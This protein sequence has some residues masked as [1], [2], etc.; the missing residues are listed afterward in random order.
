MLLPSIFISVVVCT[1]EICA[2]LSAFPLFIC[3]SRPWDNLS[4]VSRDTCD[5]CSH[6]EA[7]FFMPQTRGSC[8]HIKG[9]YDNHLSCI[10]CCGCCRFH[11]CSVCNALSDA[12]WD[13]VHSRRLYSDRAMG[14]KEAKRKKKP[15]KSVSR[16]S[17]SSRPGLERT[18]S[19]DQTGSAAEGP[20]DDFASALSRSSSGGE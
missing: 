19:A 1:V 18:E 9:T 11:G 12:T 20:D 2:F 16:T 14:K 6:F 7:S 3:P 10:N 5:N 8:G 15:R 13:L 17:S 4:P